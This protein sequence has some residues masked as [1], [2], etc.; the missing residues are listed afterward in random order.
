MVH[1]YKLREFLVN[2][3]YLVTYLVSLFFLSHYLKLK[4]L[5]F[6]LREREETF[7]LSNIFKKN[8]PLLL[9]YCGEGLCAHCIQSK[10]FH[11]EKRKRKENCHVQDF[12]QSDRLRYEEE[13]MVKVNNAL[14]TRLAS[15]PPATQSRQSA[16]FF[17]SRRNWDS[18]NP[19]PAGECA[20]PRFWGEGHTRWRERGWESPNSDEG[21]YTVALFIYSIVFCALHSRFLLLSTVPYIH[22]CTDVVGRRAM[23]LQCTA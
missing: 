19:S 1:H 23:F 7:E 4:S 13:R 12:V 18:P 16:K 21:T 5:H 9:Q 10:R 2:C 11:P 20:P 8:S 15:P 17:S 6:A 14:Y 3:C 22:A